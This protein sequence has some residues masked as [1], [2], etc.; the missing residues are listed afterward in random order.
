M[1]VAVVTDFRPFSFPLLL[2]RRTGFSWLWLIRCQSHCVAVASWYKLWPILD[3]NNWLQHNLP[4]NQ[5]CRCCEG[6]SWLLLLSGLSRE[7][8]VFAVV[9]LGSGATADATTTTTTTATAATTTTT[10]GKNSRMRINQI[11]LCSRRSGSK[12]CSWIRQNHFFAGCKK[13]LIAQKIVSCRPPPSSLEPNLNRS[14]AAAFDETEFQQKTQL[15][16]LW[17]GRSG[18]IS[19][20]QPVVPGSFP[21]AVKALFCHHLCW[22]CSTWGDETTSKGGLDW[23]MSTR[24]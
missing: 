2:P 14:E 8:V 5:K 11:R 24:L 1:A 4:S 19:S 18:S 12:S 23:T 3:S 10:T 9:I 13:N 20:F 16:W 17:G 7:W 22:R 6:F 21:V 15:F